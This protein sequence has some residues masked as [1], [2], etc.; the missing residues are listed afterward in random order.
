MWTPAQV[1]AVLGPTNALVFAS[2]YGV[3][4]QGNFEHAHDAC[5][6]GSRRAR[7]RTRRSSS[8][9]CAR[10]CSRRAVRACGRAPT[11]RCSPGGTASRSRGLV[12][13]W[14][15][16]RH[17]PALALA[18]RVGD[19]SCATTWSQAIASR[20]CTTRARPRSST[21]RSTTTRSAASAFLDLAEATGDRAWWD[22]GAKLLGAARTRFVAEEDGVVVF[23]LAPAGEPLLV[24]R[25]ESHHDGA[26]PSGAAIAVAGAVAARARRRRCGGAR[27]RREVPRAAADRRRPAST[28]A[29]ARR[30][31]AALDLYLHAQGA[32]RHRRRRAR[33]AARRCAPR[34]R[35]DPVHRGTVG[36][37]RRSSRASRAW[38]ARRA[39]TCARGRRARRRSR[40]PSALVE[41]LTRSSSSRTSGAARTPRSGSG[42]GSRRS[43]T[44]SGSTPR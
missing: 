21:A 36:A 1:R 43:R 22:L 27:A 23:Y 10:S 26:I 30:L 16:T 7:R 29:R 24:H 25:P 19:A 20:A 5:C 40:E 11:T 6:R 37:A 3:T 38:E 14:R 4:E 41:L 42:T 9:S 35:A 8:P 32:G 12:A 17:A 31:L 13:A 2:A 44:R 15:A 39:R 33:R 18:L 34:L 28:P